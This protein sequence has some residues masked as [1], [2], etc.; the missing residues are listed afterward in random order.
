MKIPRLPASLFFILPAVIIAATLLSG[1]SADSSHTRAPAGAAPAAATAAGE[2][3]MRALAVAYPDRVA[4]LA[5]RQEEYAVRIDSTWYVWAQGRL[6][7]QELQALWREYSSYRFYTYSPGSLP[8]LPSLDEATRTRLRQR[9]AQPA[10]A[11]PPRHPG[12][13][14]AVT[15]AG[16][17]TETEARLE[18]VRLMG[19]DIRV[20]ERIA[21][22]LAAVEEQ[23][24][25]LAADDPEVK[26]F[27][28]GLAGLSGYNWRDIAGTR[29]RS[30]HSYGLAFDLEPASFGGRHTYWRWALPGNE[31]W[32]AIPYGERWLVPRAVVSALEAQGFVWGG[33]WLFF[34]TMHFEY[35]PEIL[36]L[37]RWNADPG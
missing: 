20:H 2:L 13:L 16:T 32:Y 34:D 1:Q 21:A 11:S 19:F 37:A 27:I 24:T 31:D 6:L 22:P 25:R 3:E 12:F 33:K 26:S 23:L 17:R 35:R 36:L 8:P 18:T 28:A 30:Y 5:L 14:A 10:A 4:E 15:G 7:P 29:S 9:L